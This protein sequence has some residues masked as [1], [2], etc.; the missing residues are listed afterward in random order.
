MAKPAS[1]AEILAKVPIAEVLT[2]LGVDVEG[3]KKTYRGSKTRFPCS[4][5]GG[6]ADN[7][8]MNLLADDKHAA[9]SFK[10]YVCNETGDF[11]KFYAH[12]TGMDRQN[13]LKQLAEMYGS[14]EP[15]AKE[16]DRVQLGR[17]H[18]A[19]V[20]NEPALTRLAQTKGITRDTVT[21]RTLGWEAQQSRYTIPVTDAHGRVVN[22]RRYRP[23]EVD[24]ANKML[25]LPGFGSNLTLYPW[26]NLTRPATEFDRTSFSSSVRELLESKDPVIITE[27]EIK[28]LLLE[29]HGFRAVSATGGANSWSDQ[30]SKTFQDRHVYIA[31]DA[32][33]VGKEAAVRIARQIKKYARWVG[34][35]TLPLEG[36]KHQ[37]DV[38][39]YFLAANYGAQ[40]FGN[41]LLA[42]D[43]FKPR[44]RKGL[45]IGEQVY[46]VSL[47]N[48]AKAQYTGK[49][50]ETT[51]VVASKDMSPFIV[52]T[53]VRV[54]CERD[55][56]E[57]CERCAVCREGGTQA[58][59]RI[60]ELPDSDEVLLRLINVRRETQERL[61]RE[62]HGVIDCRAN[63]LEHVE[64][65]N[66]EHMRVIP[67]VDLARAESQEEDCSRVG[68][69][70]GFGIQPNTV[71][72]GQGAVLPDPRDQMA[73]LLFDEVTPAVDSLA[74][75]SESVKD[76]ELEELK[77]FRPA[78]DTPDAIDAAL[79]K[80]YDDFSHNVT[81]IYQRNDMHLFMDLCWHSALYLPGKPFGKTE[82]ERG[83][84]DMLVLGDTRQGKTE[85]A[86]RLRQH[87]G[88]GQWASAKMCT[89]AGLIGSAQKVGDRWHISW[90]IVPSA[91]RRLVVIEEAKG[92]DRE[93]IKQ[94]TDVRSSGQAQL[95]MVEKAVTFSRTRLLWLS[96]PRSD[97]SL[98]T[99]P[100][101]VEALR[102]LIGA[103]ED[104][105][106]FTA[107]MFVAS[108]EVSDKVLSGQADEPTQEHWATATLCR[109]LLLWGWTRTSNDIQYTEGA[110]L[111]IRDV[112]Q[113][114][115]KRYS[116]GIP[117]VE[118]A[119]HRFK[120][121]RLAT[122]LAIRLFSTDETMRKL[123][124]TEAHV[125]FIGEYL[126]TIYQKN[127]CGYDQWSMIEL[128][129]RSLRDEEKVRAA[130][131]EHTNWPAASQALL[132]LAEVTN[133]DLEDLFGI[134]KDRARALMAVLAQNQC[135][136]R[137]KQARYKTPA[138]IRLLKRLSREAAAGIAEVPLPPPATAATDF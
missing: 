125:H 30:L 119:D 73:V 22:V 42:T 56:G 40:D 87:Y 94:L 62:I 88:I 24:P 67:A 29:Q 21:R 111:A 26:D 71:Y 6:E 79:E 11:A 36:S 135:L 136:R 114:Q 129:A 38:T 65:I 81:G 23:G 39:D 20:A 9:G 124:V 60:F 97:R 2:R 13:A 27:G 28:A 37:K 100:F 90:G 61:L 15:L 74:E 108:G 113:N 78:E 101:G 133:A 3:R 52:P 54:Q 10:C 77:V 45:N 25:S 4:F 117:L 51:F 92:M 110:L 14:P 137:I 128:Q 69:R 115:A 85:T 33:K 82:P 131:L 47:L 59:D 96:N 83:W 19:L 57:R 35:V 66:I 112:V 98:D 16:V 1:A 64:T 132:Q 104:I 99:Y 55:Q 12:S 120:I 68:Y 123:V 126:D 105:A 7:L 8:E 18:T 106:R 102:E 41:L 49:R 121:A 5:H 89:R 138:F 70:I 72:V 103:Q 48:A 44:K 32:D 116:P 130:I 58:T 86:Q 84:C 134:E 46:Q 95:I 80:L 76:E 43:E 75:F 50:I 53:K 109:R 122:A 31:L 107:V 93:V 127:C 34:I 91:D 63:T 118:P 17:W